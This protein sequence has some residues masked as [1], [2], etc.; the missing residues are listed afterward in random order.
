MLVRLPGKKKEFLTSSS[1]LSVVNPALWT[2]D[3]GKTVS[4]W[5]HTCFSEVVLGRISLLSDTI[6]LKFYLMSCGSQW[7]TIDNFFPSVLKE[8][9]AK[10]KWSCDWLSYNLHIHSHM[11]SAWFALEG[12]NSF[13][14]YSQHK[15]VVRSV[16]GSVGFLLVLKLFWIFLLQ[17]LNFLAMSPILKSELGHIRFLSGIQIHWLLWAE[18]LMSRG[19]ILFHN[20]CIL[21]SIFAFCVCISHKSPYFVLLLLRFSVLQA[22]CMK[23][24]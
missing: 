19:Q 17:D 22:D 24:N 21:L 9:Y 10:R 15:L 2:T 7:L 12:L 16:R 3:T 8:H 20:L 13:S 4:C 5:L 11:C 23:G 1:S 14:S 18:R 6:S